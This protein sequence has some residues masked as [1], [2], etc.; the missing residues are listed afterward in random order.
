MPNI[1][2]PELPYRLLRLYTDL[3]TR[4]S[5]CSLKLEGTLPKEGAVIIAPNHSN[6][7][8]D[9][10]VV[11][12][13]RP[14]GIVFGARA[15][16]FKN[17]TAAKALH[18]L[19]ILPMARERDGNETIRE[20]IYAFDEVDNTL[21]HGVP[22]C[23]FPEGR[24]RPERTLLPLQKGVGRIAFRS[25]G[26]RPTCIVPVGINYSHFFRYRGRCLLRVGTPI[27]VNAFLE[28]HQALSEAQQHQVLRE[29]LSKRIQAL[30]QPDP[31]PAPSPW[32]WLLLPLWPAAAILSLPQWLTAEILCRKI[33][34]KAFCNSVRYLVR[35]LLTPLTFLIW[36]L[37][38]FILLPWPWAVGL[39]VG[40]LFSYSIFYDILY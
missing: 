9:A 31:L 16:I 5:Y 2:K 35:L 4:A 20:S 18:F 12:L 10:L 30:V 29:E 36:A 1:W 3:C 21:S 39:L 37:L 19:K 34:D 40:Y 32:R 8:L 11:L 22:F 7:L 14:E 33:K 25:A 28:E 24:H 6:T 13:L 15:D 38:L 27:D 17:P 26:Q 23:L